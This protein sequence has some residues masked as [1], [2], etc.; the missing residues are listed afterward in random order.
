MDNEILWVTYIEN[1]KPIYFITSDKLREFYKL[2]NSNK[3]LIKQSKNPV[4][5][6]KFIYTSEQQS[7]F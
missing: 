7:L 4:E 6:E 2:Y 1:N 3:K 5:L